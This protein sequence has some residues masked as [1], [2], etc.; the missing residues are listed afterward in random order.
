MEPAALAAGTTVEVE[1]LYYNT[2]ARRKFLKSE[3]TKGRQ[4]YI[5]Y[6]IIEESSRLDLQ[7]AKAEFERLR[8]GPLSELRVALIHGAMYRRDGTRLVSVT[9]EGL[10]RLRR[11]A[12]L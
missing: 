4:G 7:S 11:E 3:A 6:P 2:P 10:L 1:E 5:V 8:A 9:Q 12:A